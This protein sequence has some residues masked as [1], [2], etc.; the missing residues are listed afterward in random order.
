MS[1]L[2]QINTSFSVSSGEK[3]KKSYLDGFEYE[4]ILEKYIQIEMNECHSSK[5]QMEARS[6]L[7][8]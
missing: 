3:I 6:R 7:S 5:N 8:F 2:E 4:I 1:D